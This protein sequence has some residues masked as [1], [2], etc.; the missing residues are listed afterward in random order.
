MPPR[1]LHDA[2]PLPASSLVGMKMALVLLL[3]LA[4]LLS[5]CGGRTAHPRQAAE[6]RAAESDPI[7]QLASRISASHGDLL[8]GKFIPVEL[9]A[10]APADSLVSRVFRPVLGRIRVSGLDS[11]TGYRIL[12]IRQLRIPG[13]LL[14]D[15]CTFALVSLDLGG[16][17]SSRKLVVLRYLGHNEWWNRVFDL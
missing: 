12:E 2:P 14:P 11:V 17:R 1:S 10:T 9:P 16:S 5:G 15:T 7:E 6:P 3:V 13:R 4:G 8:S